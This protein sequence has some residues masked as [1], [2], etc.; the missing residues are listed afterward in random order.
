[1]KLKFY[2][3]NGTS[4]RGNISVPHYFDYNRYVLQ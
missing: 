1:M 4:E 2:Y 3:K